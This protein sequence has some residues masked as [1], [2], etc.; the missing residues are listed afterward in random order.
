M[1]HVTVK[2]SILALLLAGTQAFAGQYDVIPLDQKCAGKVVTVHL[3]QGVFGNPNDEVILSYFKNLDDIYIYGRGGNDTICGSNGDDLLV[4][5]PGNDAIYGGRGNDTI[6]G[7]TGE[8][9]LHGNGGVDKIR[10]VP[11]MMNCSGSSG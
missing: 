3:Y 10:A 11:A 1:K 8:D 9:S 5:G 6:I 7:S 2:L 4:G